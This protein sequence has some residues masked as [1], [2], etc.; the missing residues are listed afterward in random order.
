MKKVARIALTLTIL[1]SCVGAAACGREFGGTKDDPGSGGAGGEG[2]DAGNSTGGQDGAPDELSI[3]TS[4]LPAADYNMPYSARLAG[5]PEIDDWVWKIVDGELPRGLT[6]SASGLL[7]GRPL[8]SGTFEFTVSLSASGLETVE[9]T[10]TL[11]VSR[12]RWLAY[13]SDEGKLGVDRLYVVDV[14]NELFRKTMISTG[15][16]D[17][18]D[19]HG[20]FATRD[21]YSAK[22]WPYN[23]DLSP[24]ARDGRF[25][26]YVADKTAT[27]VDELFVV[28]VSGA[29]PG[30]PV[31]LL[32]TEH[33]RSFAWSP[34]GHEIAALAGE[35]VVVFHEDD[36]AWV[37]EV[38]EGAP[39]EGWLEWPLD[40]VLFVS[41]A[42]DAE[43]R[44]EDGG[45]FGSFAEVDRIGSVF[46]VNPENSR[47]VFQS[48][49]NCGGTAEVVDYAEGTVSARFSGYTQFNPE[50]T[51]A[52]S[53]SSLMSRFPGIDPEAEPSMTFA[54]YG[55]HMT[56]SSDGRYTDAEDSSPGYGYFLLD[57]ESNEA[58]RI[59]GQIENQYGYSNRDFSRDAGWYHFGL[60]GAYVTRLGKD[61]PGPART[62]RP[63]GQG[64]S[65]YRDFSP[66]SAMI[67]DIFKPTSDSTQIYWSR[68]DAEDEW[69]ALTAIPL[70]YAT[71][72]EPKRAAWSADGA[73][74]AA[75]YGPVGSAVG[76]T[77]IYVTLA[78]SSNAKLHKISG[79]LSCAS[80]TCPRVR[81][82]DFQP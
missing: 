2:G 62:L 51:E 72:A 77:D 81:W 16:P 32:L 41:A 29:S 4:K 14:S 43:V 69:S 61:G 58:V 70:E 57:G 34:S 30:D 82:Y 31:R 15:L 3:T 59:E 40:S 19:V 18:A 74:L 80:S 60:T 23:T 53:Y 8:E 13:L 75:L 48:W 50:V 68:L 38:I 22:L 46:Q 63:G 26:A 7:S 36:G 66:N 55:C 20:Y 65:S 71:S 21:Y 17:T 28:D 56:W 12:K 42:P 10:L 64:A 33:V 44:R 73:A 67:F 79:Y 5:A 37:E 1:G 49:D 11:V 47:V 6:L 39:G 54:S 78:N 24:F 45:A 27:G 9:R 52:V 76:P 25:I 35:E